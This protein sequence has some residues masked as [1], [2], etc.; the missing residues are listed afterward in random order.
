MNDIRRTILW[1]IFG[2]SMILLWDQWQIYNGKQAT[3]FPNPAKTAAPAAGGV[4]AAT[5]TPTASAANT[6]AAKTNTTAAPA[7]ADALAS[8]AKR[9]K[10]VISTDVLKLGFDTE[11]AT[12]ERAELL[13]HKEEGAGIK[14][15]LI[16]I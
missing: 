8:S 6:A 4:A 2:F 13:Q 1:V 11:G 14:L 15:S 10:V 3:F 5:P 9:E 12:L 16:H 7:A